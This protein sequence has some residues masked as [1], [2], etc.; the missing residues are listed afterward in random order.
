MAAHPLSWLGSLFGRVPAEPEPPA[1][2]FGPPAPGGVFSRA[3]LDER[4]T[5]SLWRAALRAAAQGDAE[6]LDGL[7]A[8]PSA[9]LSLF[10]RPPNPAAAELAPAA[11]N[12][13]PSEDETPLGL[14]VAQAI[15]AVQPGFESF[16]DGAQFSPDAADAAQ[17][18][19]APCEAHEAGG[20][21]DASDADDPI[22]RPGF[23]D[24]ASRVS[25]RVLSPKNLLRLA[26]AL[27]TPVEMNAA[28]VRR[29]R[30][31]RLF[32]VSGVHEAAALAFWAR[33]VAASRLDDWSLA[34]AR[35]AAPA[36]LACE[37]IDIELD[38]PELAKP[39]SFG[40]CGDP[41]RVMA[42][43]ALRDPAA[44]KLAVELLCYADLEEPA[45]GQTATFGVLAW[46]RALLALLL[47]DVCAEE[48]PAVME[49]AW[50]AGIKLDLVAPL[51]VA[52]QALTSLL[53]PTRQGP[54][55]A[56]S[57]R[58]DMASLRRA[59][60]RVRDL[61]SRAGAPLRYRSE[62]WSCVRE[63]AE[64]ES[65]FLPAAGEPARAGHRIGANG[66]DPLP[67]ARSTDQEGGQETAAGSRRGQ[68]RRL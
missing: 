56:A 41:W 36:L 16:A 31:G 7:L 17:N 68:A 52:R 24:K 53:F 51:R 5:R 44:F 57:W 28:M 6:P 45:A 15:C 14:L 67:S 61:E 21:A 42:F 32:G 50:R 2:R 60:P 49:A 22:E 1:S 8:D 39:L 62:R 20:D 11:A 48:D 38:A 33:V 4:E 37:S 47:Q 12:R 3:A 40:F 26:R 54:T 63:N 27:E 43:A 55:L 66:R 58:P 64:I 19:R 46:D 30:Q 23:A 18:A 9:R 65:L 25:P 59:Q 13:A 29:N 10:E 35:F 34:S